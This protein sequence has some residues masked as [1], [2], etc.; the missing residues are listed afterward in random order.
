MEEAA[1]VAE[2]VA[3]EAEGEEGEEVPKAQGEKQE[4]GSGRGTDTKNST[5]SE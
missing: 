4:V 5:A 3:E 1:E 2:E